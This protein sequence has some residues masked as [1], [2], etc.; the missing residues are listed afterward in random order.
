MQIRINPNFYKANFQKHIMGTALIT[1]KI[2]PESPSIDLKAIEKQAI[3]IVEKNQGKKPSVR[4]EPIAF[5]LV[6]VI[7]NFALDE[8]LSIDD[9]EN[10]LKTIEGVSSAEVIDFR[11]AFG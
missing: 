3:A 11:R 10:P 6:A 2:M 5:G 1:I 4:T 8:S 9:I 7:I